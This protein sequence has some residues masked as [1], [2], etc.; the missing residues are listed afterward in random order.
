MITDKALRVKPTGKNTWLTDKAPKGHGRFC[1]R[2]TPTGKKMFYFRFTDHNGKREHL[3]IGGYDPQGTT[4]L[5]L[6]EAR[7]R[8]GEFSRL[9]QTGVLDIKGYFEEQDRIAAIKRK[10][11]EIRI[12]NERLESER[13][14]NR[15]TIKALFDKWEKAQ[16][17]TRKDKGAYVLRMFNKDVFPMIGTMYA[18][19]VKK[20]HIA[21]VVDNILARGINRTAKMVF[22]DMRQMFKWAL[23]RDWIEADPTASIKKSDVGKKDTERDRV[24]SEDEITSLA[25][26]MPAA[27]LL[28]TTEA[29][30]WIALSTCCRIGELLKSKWEH[31]DTEK[32]EWI[33]PAE[34]AKN[35]FAII[36]H[37]S[38][39]TLKQFETIR[40]L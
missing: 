6:K 22:S 29:A 13:Q 18:D 37:L 3:P 28:P 2:I 23:Y 39:F 14:R 27:R 34:N 36:I 1:A 24:L 10:T 32:R 30:V 33:I 11:E 21:E 20:G 8:A 17:I 9:Y 19:E 5:T 38:D 16:L 31:I 4:G 12:E 35:G 15:L 40:T 26:Q 25:R 7:E